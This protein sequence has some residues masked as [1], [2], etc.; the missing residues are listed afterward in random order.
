MDS[1]SAAFMKFVMVVRLTERSIIECVEQEEK[2]E[3]NNNKNEYR[4]AKRVLTILIG[5]SSTSRCHPLSC[6]L[7]VVS[8]YRQKMRYRLQRAMD[9]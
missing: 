1:S 4:V 3:N 9:K 2:K 7:T 6:I 8:V 5:Y